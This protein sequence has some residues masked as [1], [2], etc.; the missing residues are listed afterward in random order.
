LY[1]RLNVEGVNL[2]GVNPIA[3]NFVTVFV[4]SAIDTRV[5]PLQLLRPQQL[6]L[7]IPVQ[8]SNGSVKAQVK[9]VRAEVQDGFLR[10][11]ITYDFSGAKG[12]APQG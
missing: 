8:A 3:N 6:Q 2:E 1:G 5:N 11:H 10:L 4:R 12:Q 9:D 7:A